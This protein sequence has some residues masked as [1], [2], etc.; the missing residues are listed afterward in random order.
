MISAEKLTRE[1]RKH[2]PSARHALQAL[3]LDE[4][5]LNNSGGGSGG[6]PDDKLKTFRVD[7]ERLI[8]GMENSLPEGAI[9]RL[10]EFLEERIPLDTIPEDHPHAARVKELAGRDVEFERSAAEADRDASGEEETTE[11]LREFLRKHGMPETGIDGA[12][13]IARKI[14]RDKKRGHDNEFPLGALPRNA[15][16]GGYGGALSRSLSRGGLGMDGLARLRPD[17]ATSTERLS[18]RREVAVGKGFATRFP[19]VARVF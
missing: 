18:A 2:F 9:G 6:N 14:I 7:L 10:L 5:L 3:G 4:D 19:E 17:L 11:K 1:L 12:C 16:K 13:D 8:G 15:Q